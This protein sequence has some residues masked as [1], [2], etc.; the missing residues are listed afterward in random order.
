[1]GQA[2]TGV[3]VPSR[4][5]YHRPHLDGLR[6]IAVYLV[7]A[8]HA[9]LGSFRGGFIGVDI[10]F[11]LS[12]YLVTRILLR[13]LAGTNRVDL[14]RF[15]ARR[16]RRILPAAFAM[17]I[18]T[19]VAF[20]VLA[21]P[22]RVL[23]RASDFR[24]AFLYTANWHLIAQETDYFASTA[25]SSPLLHY[26]SL[27]VEEQ[28]YFVWPLALGALFLISR[29]AGRAQWWVLRGLIAIGACASAYAALHISQTHL[30]R[31]Y[32]GTDTR[33]YQLL[34]GAL[35]AM[36]PQLFSLGTRFARPAG[37]IAAISLVGLIAVSTSGYD[38]SVIGRG[39]VTVAL[40]CALIIALEAST[41]GAARRLLSQ[42]RISYLGRISYATYLWHWPIIFLYTLDHTADPIELFGL[43]T[44]GATALA[45]LSY[46][47]LEHPVRS[48]R[49]LDGYRVPV[50]AVGLT[51]SVV[52]GLAIAPAILRWNTNANTDASNV[53]V[54]VPSIETGSTRLVDWR[55]ADADIPPRPNCYR[56]AVENCTIVRGTGA[57]ILVMGDS[58]ARMWGATFAEIGKREGLTVSIAASNGCPWQ[59]DII[60]VPTSKA[61]RNDRDD[62]YDRVISELEPDIIVLTQQAYDAIGNPFLVQSRFGKTVPVSSPAGS[63]TFA[64]AS[65]RSIG[66]LRAGGHKVVV[67]RSLPRP[68]DPLF[69]PLG[70]L[71]KGD[72]NC[73]FQVNPN[74]RPLNRY[75]SAAAAQQDIWY[76][77]FNR[78][79]CPRFPMCDP[80]VNDVIVWRDQVHL[81]PT[82]SRLLAPAVAA[83]LHSTGILP[84]RR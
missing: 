58:T 43:S 1:M 29:R 16:F 79:A 27:A 37:W 73:R 49:A 60:M 6:C 51:I 14:V 34:A 8:Y 25:G 56:R 83:R 47:F 7:V 74:P 31:A 80:V 42:P 72:A 41:N 55:V 26:W 19:A 13:D 77:D 68:Q 9:G 78:L 67:I 10:F 54:S 24:A 48:S 4:P 70:C 12:G 18:I 20:A 57:S 2:D 45:A 75:Y 84:P 81:T 21:T 39:F 40:T 63:S 28:F 50:I 59:R 38:V 61:C 66:R 17:L 23:T 5:D 82:Y 32:Y 53:S 33:A 62:W 46:H 3:V 30:G 36:S 22:L 65:A 52:A 35:L 15:Y 69:N 11:V 71:S 44:V 76:L 64:V